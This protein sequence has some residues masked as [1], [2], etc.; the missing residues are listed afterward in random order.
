M[1][2]SHMPAICLARAANVAT[3]AW[4]KL[5]DVFISLPFLTF[6]SVVHAVH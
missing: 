4:T 2:V 1:Q 3:H 6:M 5:H